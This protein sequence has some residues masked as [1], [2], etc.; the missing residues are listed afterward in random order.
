MAAKNTAGSNISVIDGKSMS[1]G[2]G[3]CIEQISKVMNKNDLS[4]EEVVKKLR[5]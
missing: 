5:K 1:V 4:H 2:M 3:L